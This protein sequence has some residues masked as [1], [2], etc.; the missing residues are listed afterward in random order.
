MDI[1][2]IDRE[3][4]GTYYRAAQLKLPE[5]A[6][7]TEHLAEM[8]G[9]PFGETLRK[10][11]L[12]T[13]MLLG[14]EAIIMILALVVGKLSAKNMLELLDLSRESLQLQTSDG[15][16][17]FKKTPQWYAHYQGHMGELAPSIKLFLEAQYADF[18]EGLRTLAPDAPNEPGDLLSKGGPSSEQ[19]PNT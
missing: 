2:H 19:F 12:D 11:T 5:W 9:K 17:N 10:G 3:I 8:L 1:P 18:F 7:L 15:G 14:G 13:D 16:Y 4:G 6:K